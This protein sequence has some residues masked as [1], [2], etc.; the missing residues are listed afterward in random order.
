MVRESA[1]GS[2]K[3]STPPATDARRSLGMRMVKGGVRRNSVVRGHLQG[4]GE[5]F[6]LEQGTAAE[7]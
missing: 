1:V 7:P 4:G 2:D 5:G 6:P 3:R